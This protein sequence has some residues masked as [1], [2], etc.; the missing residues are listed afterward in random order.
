M[1]FT[2]VVAVDLLESN[3]NMLRSA[4]RELS[5]STAMLQLTPRLELVNA[6]ASDDASKALFVPKRI[7]QAGVES[8]SAS[9]TGRSAGFSRMLSTTVDQ[10]SE[11]LNLATIDI[12]SVDVSPWSFPEAAGLLQIAIVCTELINVP[13]A[14]PSSCYYTPGPDLTLTLTLT[15]TLT[16]AFK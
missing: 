9:K 10:L 15:M 12:L 13:N 4:F 14:A 11:Q 8:V 6:A 16:L 3:I 7:A 5:N 2:T 1:P